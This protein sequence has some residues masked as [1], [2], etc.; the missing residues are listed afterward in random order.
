[1]QRD[2]AASFVLDLSVLRNAERQSTLFEQTIVPRAQALVDA[3]RSAYG[4]GRGGFGEGVD[5]ERGALDARL[6]P[7]E[8]RVEREKALIAIETWSKLDLEAMH[9]VRTAA[10]PRP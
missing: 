8:L 4:V 10:G 6:T 7:A 9:P 3:A 1:Y 5:G 2:L